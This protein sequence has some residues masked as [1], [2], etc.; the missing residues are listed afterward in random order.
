ML[1]RLTLSSWA[2]AILLLQAP[3]CGH[4]ICLLCLVTVPPLNVWTWPPFWFRLLWVRVCC[5]WALGGGGTKLSDIMREG[6][7]LGS[8]WL[9]SNSSL[10]IY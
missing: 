10:S 3:E 4:Y 5:R 9:G 8:D 1:F 6:F 2:Q 7:C